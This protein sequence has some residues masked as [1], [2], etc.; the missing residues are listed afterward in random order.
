MEVSHKPCPFCP[1]SDAFSYNSDTGMFKCFLYN[2]ENGVIFDLR[3][4]R[5]AGWIK[6]DGYRQL[7]YMDVKYYSHRVA[8]FLMEGRWPYQI[9]HVNRNRSDNRWSNLRE[10]NDGQQ[11]VNKSGWG[12][13]GLKGVWWSKTYSKWQSQVRYKGKVYHIGYFD[14]V[15]EAKTA[16]D[17]KAKELHGEYFSV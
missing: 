2:P 1:S 10:V 3:Y 9:D 12:S 5:E 17:K 11:S 7:S 13:S 14:S 15:T 4:G 16:R 8:F 6:H